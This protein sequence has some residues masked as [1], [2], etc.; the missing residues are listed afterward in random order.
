[1]RA[2][3]EP[4]Q[5]HEDRRHV[6]QEEEPDVVDGDD[7]VG[8]KRPG[9]GF[10]PWSFRKWEMGAVVISQNVTVARRVG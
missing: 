7:G 3:E 8:S 6:V 1:M 10:T 2:E 5:Q 4:V 9:I